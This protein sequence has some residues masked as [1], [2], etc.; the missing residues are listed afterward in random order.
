MILKFTASSTGRE[1]CSCALHLP[2]LGFCASE[3][4]SLLQSQ[5]RAR[6]SSESL[7]GFRHAGE[8]GRILLF[9][10]AACYLLCLII[11]IMCQP[12]GAALTDRFHCAGKTS[13]THRT[14][15]KSLILWGHMQPSRR[16]IARERTVD[17]SFIYF[18]VPEWLD[19]EGMPYLLPD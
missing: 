15:A 18:S 9:W 13:S 14:A 16:P 12:A 2:L 19:R 6:S 5:W 7:P 11:F 17:S 8:T 3:S 4:Q 1:A 10:P